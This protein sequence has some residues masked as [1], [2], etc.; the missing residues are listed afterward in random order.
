LCGDWASATRGDLLLLRKA[1]K[2]GW[3]V[4][5]ERRGP[6]LEAAFS[7]L[8]RQDKPVRL[9]LAACRLAIAAD[10]HNVKLAKA[11]E[12]LLRLGACIDRTDLPQP[13]GPP[14]AGP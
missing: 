5:P 13:Q 4:P 11:L 9:R 6:L 12:A 1:I 14:G 8:S 10:E 2:E 7:A 3:P